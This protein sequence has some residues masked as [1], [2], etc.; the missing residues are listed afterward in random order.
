MKE[1]D[2]G[3]I[4]KAVR[5]ILEALGEDP[6]REG[7]VETPERV[8]RFYLEVFDGL[9]RDPG[10]EIDAFFGEE[11][12]QEIVMVREIPFYSMCE[13][14]LVPFHG[15]AHVAYM[16]KGR[17]TG[18]SKLARLVEGYARRPQMQERL[19][20]Q[21]ADALAERLEPLGVMVVIE[22]EH[23][24]MSMRGREKAGS[25]DGDVGRAGDHAHQPGHPRRGDVAALRH[26]PLRA[27][28][29][30]WL[31]AR[32]GP[33]RV[34]WRADG[35]AQCHPRFLLRWRASTLRPPM[36]S[37]PGWRCVTP[38]PGSSMSVESRPAP[39]PNRS[40]SRRNWH[41][42]SPSSSSSP[43]RGLLISIDTS[44]PEV[45]ERRHRR[46]RRDPQR[47][48]RLFGS[49]DG[50]VGGRDRGWGGPD[51]HEGDPAET[52]SRILNTTTWSLRSPAFSPNEP[53]ILIG[54]GV[55]PEAIA[56]DPGIGF[57]KT[58]DHN[59][60]LMAG[61]PDLAAL[62][63]PVV[64]GASRKSF[65]GK[66]TGIEN[67]VRQGWGDRSDHG[68]R[69]R[70]RSKG[71]SGPRCFFVKGSAVDSRHYRGPRAMGRMVAGLKPRGFTWVITD[72]LA[73]SERVGGSGFQ[74]RRV[75][76]EEEITWLVEEAGINSV[77][78]MLPGNQNLL[79]Y[80]EA[81]MAT[82]SVPVAPTFEASE[83]EAFFATLSKAMTRNR[84]RV[85]VHRET[86]DD[87]VGGLLG[88]YLVVSGLVKDPILALAVIQQILG[89][90]LGP[91]G[92]SLIPA[93]ADS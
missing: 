66:I 7:L 79:A 58:V 19:T 67:P 16:P 77:V 2:Q 42:S 88:G 75:R 84:A 49:G 87:T 15:Q 10:D 80:K 18:L 90:A 78:S 91:E 4:E 41:G 83:I 24:C 39:G 86:I 61:L 21:V 46:R 8:A 36:R 68:P 81:G 1:I 76:R 55:G 33:R 25:E 60:Q 6:E 82:Y 5:E 17:V 73:V 31:L 34:P 52:C 53:R 56:I 62:G 22:A 71:F 45:A 48:H 69:I 57:G 32:R 40:R 3:R 27:L 13:H 12:Y 43:S 54:L 20:A 64:L 38:G 70:A 92:R 93:T 50:R 14:H 74:H 30:I 59:L 85:L 9:H 44:K 28:S 63:Y 23:L 11:R 47:R 35:G 51:A 65:L 72:R 89:R 26:R 29:Q 37:P